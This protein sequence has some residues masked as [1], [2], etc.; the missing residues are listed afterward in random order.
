ML[1]VAQRASVWCG[2]AKRIKLVLTLLIAGGAIYLVDY[3]STKATI[4]VSGVVAALAMEGGGGDGD[5]DHALTAR[6]AAG[7]NGRSAK[8]RPSNV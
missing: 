4:I 8:I 5:P 1:D 7:A 3:P 2:N 6:G